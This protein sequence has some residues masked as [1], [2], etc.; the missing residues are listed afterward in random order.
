[1]PPPPL[2]SDEPLLAAWVRR[3]DEEAFRALAQKYTALVFGAALRK[4]GRADWAEEVTQE[5]FVIF[6]RRA[7]GLDGDGGLAGWLHRTAV[8]TAATRVRTES[9][10]DQRMQKLAALSPPDDQTPPFG[11]VSER[12]W[13]QLLPRLDDA[14]AA[15]PELDRRVILEHYFER[16]TYAEVAA[17]AGLTLEAARKRGLRAL[18][19]L[20]RRLSRRGA[21]LP[22]AVLGGGLAAAF[23]QSAPAA[24]VVQSGAAGIAAVSGYAASGTS[25]TLLSLI[26]MKSILISSAAVVL[27]AGS[28][29]VFWPKTSETQVTETGGG[30]AVP[31]TTPG[32]DQLPTQRSASFA[33]KTNPVSPQGNTAARAVVPP[34]APAPASPKTSQPVALDPALKEAFVNH[35]R[36]KLAEK[37]INVLKKGFKSLMD[38]SRIDISHLTN[39]IYE[40]KKTEADPSRSTAEQ[41]A[42]NTKI[43]ELSAHLNER[44]EDLDTFRATVEAWVQTEVV[45]QRDSILEEIKNSKGSLPEMEPEGEGLVLNGASY[46][47]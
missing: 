35:P 8:L 22:V 42:A 20:H 15:L 46:K 44:Q 10:R 40:A 21:D 32:T 18:E 36:T 38:R 1:M 30:A 3:R 7:S 16:K 23:R 27:L 11:Q 33:A 43:V 5:V 31:L 6:A 34:V 2:C 4:T 47:N 25:V 45:A 41:T 14:L 28:T 12:D 39:Q 29:I 26:T 17:Q 37:R 9:R 19:K 13:A 24:L